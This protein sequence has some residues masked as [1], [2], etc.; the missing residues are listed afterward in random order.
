MREQLGAWLASY[1]QTMGAAPLLSLIA[2]GLLI[3]YQD[4]MI[5]T[6]HRLMAE[7][8]MRARAVARNRAR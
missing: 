8:R 6:D 3:S 1:P 7:A 5:G 2:A 4:S